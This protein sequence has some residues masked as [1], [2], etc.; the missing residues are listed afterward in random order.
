MQGGQGW[1]VFQ[2]MLKSVL[3]GL[4]V[5]F[6]LLIKKWFTQPM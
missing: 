4:T 1:D 6:A 2:V 5:T 3:L